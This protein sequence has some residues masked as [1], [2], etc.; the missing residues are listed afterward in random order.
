VFAKVKQLLRSLA[1][2]TKDAL[3]K[4]MQSILDQV[5]TNDAINC[6]KHCGYTLRVE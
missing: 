3:W 1:C 6:F 4:A 2:R 5:T